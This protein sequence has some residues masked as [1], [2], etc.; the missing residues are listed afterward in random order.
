MTKSAFDKIAAGLED[1]ILI[2]RGEA[3]PATYRVHVPHDIDVRAIRKRAGLTQAAFA[4]R[5]GFS[6]A[7]VRDW[8]QKR[9]RP[10][11]SARILLKVIEL[12]PEAVEEALGA[13]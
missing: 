2:A 9:R 3:D 12:R 10:E 7:A 6:A 8:E 5:Y 4:A 11:A 1:A 13:P